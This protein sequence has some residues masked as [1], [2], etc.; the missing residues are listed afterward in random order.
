MNHDPLLQHT[1]SDRP[2][3]LTFL[4]LFAAL[5][6]VVTALAAVN[7]SLTGPDQPPAGAQPESQSHPIPGSHQ[8]KAT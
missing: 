8:G 6:A 2:P 7:D 3:I 5:L 4:L 1:M